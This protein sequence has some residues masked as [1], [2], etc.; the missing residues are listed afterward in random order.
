MIED[1]LYPFQEVGATW[2][3]GNRV[4]LLADEMGIGKTVQAIR[5][6]D[7]IGAERVA[8]ICPAS[9]RE[10]WAAEFVR[11]SPKPREFQIPYTREALLHSSHSKILSY[12]LARTLSQAIRDNETPFD[13]LILDEFHY[14]KTPGAIQTLAVLGKLGLVHHA[15]RIWAL[16]GTPA[17]NHA[18]ELWT[19]LYTFGA[20]KLGYDA[21]VER[22]CK[23]KATHVPGYGTRHQISGNNAENIPELKAILNRVMLRRTKEEV[24]LQL[25][26]IAFTDVVVPAGVVD[27]E[28]E[29]SFIQYVRNPA[30]LD[31]L[32]NQER[33]LVDG[34]IAKAGLGA[35]T[36]KA[37]EAMAG[38]VS[39]LRRYT[40]LQKVE[41]VANLV[42]EELTANA[43]EKI[44]IFAIH[45]DVI[46]GI[47]TRLRKFGAV[48]Y[49]GGHTP[50]TKADHL[51]RF[52]KRKK[53]RVF[54]VNIT[55]GG[56]GVDGLQKVSHEG[57]FAEQ[58]WNPSKNAQAA[59]RLHRI[60]Q[61]KPVRIRFA[62]LA[63]SSDQRV[64]NVLK[65]KSRDLAAI[66]NV[67]DLQTAMNASSV[68][69]SDSSEGGE[70]EVN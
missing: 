51:E 21:F 57:L 49:Y 47:R 24:M 4:A 69:D 12:D 67:G 39:T 41:G 46:E 55:A 68:S 58:E 31:E 20:T 48:T 65:R 18:G 36:M 28:M 54:I 5:A 34:L 50:E 11:W 35:M 16:S 70:N 10:Q 14:L 7:L 13:V 9:V 8:V 59:M 52:M 40:G 33:K 15:K 42:A 27:I 63:N 26:K 29:S 25:P 45:R 44:V 60:G 37:L 66:Y 19:L 43:Y 6:S 22:Y 53:C 64:A 38:S 23:T 62:G 32:L 1:Q 56:T 61:D 30:E 3:A 2:L 17:S